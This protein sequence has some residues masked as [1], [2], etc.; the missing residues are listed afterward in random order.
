MGVTVAQAEYSMA[1]NRRQQTGPGL[2]VRALEFTRGDLARVL[3]SRGRATKC[4]T[5]RVRVVC[6]ARLPRR[7]PPLIQ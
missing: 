7:H 1:S 5:I 2:T 4:S 3:S 6:F